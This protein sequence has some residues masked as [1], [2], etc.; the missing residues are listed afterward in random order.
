[1]MRLTQTRFYY[2]VITQ[3]GWLQHLLTRAA[4]LPGRNTFT[5]GHSAIV[6]VVLAHPAAP[7]S[8]TGVWWG[9]SMVAR[10]LVW[11]A[12]LPWKN[13]FTEGQSAIVVVVL[14]HATALFR[15][16]GVSWGSSMKARNRR[17]RLGSRP[18]G[19]YTCKRTQRD[20]LFQQIVWTC[21][22]HN[23]NWN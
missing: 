10:I 7:L 20:W 13:T 23:E 15:Y 3:M 2:D 8:R 1:M 16:T 19:T 11:A 4:A 9:S 12:A 17:F 6:V 18:G 14:A 21:Q 22:E 5:V